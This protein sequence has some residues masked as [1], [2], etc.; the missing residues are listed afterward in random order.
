MKMALFSTDTEGIDALFAL[1]DAANVLL[2]GSCQVVN[3]GD[4]L[5]VP[6]ASGVCVTLTFPLDPSTDFV[7]TVATAGVPHTAFFTAHLPTEFERDIHYLMQNVADL[8]TA[9]PNEPEA[10]TTQYCKIQTGTDG[11]K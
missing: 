4:T 11:V 9:T 2:S 6:T 1:R 8:T 7:A 5:P 3:T 10:D